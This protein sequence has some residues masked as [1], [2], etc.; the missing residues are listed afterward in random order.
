MARY[1]ASAYFSALTEG[2]ANVD[3]VRRS[4]KIRAFA[5][6]SPCAPKVNDF[7]WCVS[8]ARHR[9]MIGREA[10]ERENKIACVA[11]ACPSDLNPGQAKPFRFS[12]N[13]IAS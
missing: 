13:C 11:K 6:A 3:D 5:M 1:G 9:L 2:S 10:S 7:S 12:P 4:S 8:P